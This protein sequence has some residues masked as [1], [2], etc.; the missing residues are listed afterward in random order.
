MSKRVAD[1][2]VEALQAAGV[3]TCYGIVGDTLNRIAHVIDR[4]EID[5]GHVRREEAGAFAASAKA[6][7]TGFPPHPHANM[8]IITYVRKGAI[9]QKDSLGN[10]GRT[11]AG[12]VQVMS[13][14]S[15]IGHAEYNL[16]QRPTRIFHIWIIPTHRGG[17]PAWSSQPF[18]KGDRSGR[19]VTLGSGFDKDTDALPIR[20]DARV[21]GATLKAGKSVDYALGAQRHG[22]LLPASGAVEVN[23]TRIDASDGAAIQDGHVIQISAIEDSE[24]VL[25]TPRK[26]CRLDRAHIRSEGRKMAKVLVLYYSAYGPILPNQAARRKS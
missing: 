17:S 23:G 9:T 11:Q 3:K 25:S 1:V 18:P 26:R 12:D 19:F 2:L 15:G 10:E 16:E 14:G 24:L 7:N 22:Y 20:T 5:W 6:P 21:L 8:E 4:S 13:A